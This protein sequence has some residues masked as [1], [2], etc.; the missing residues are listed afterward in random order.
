MCGRSHISVFLLLGLQAILPSYLSS[1]FV[2]A[3][4]GYI[5]CNAEGQFMCKDNDCWCQCS[6]EFPQCNCPEADIRSQ[7]SYLERMREAWRQENQEFQESG[8][9]RFCFSPFL[10]GAFLF[11]PYVRCWCPHSGAS[12]FN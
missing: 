10:C 8:A 2:Q 3:A 9:K 4:L 1:S 6:K 12:L 5:G 11:P 7:E